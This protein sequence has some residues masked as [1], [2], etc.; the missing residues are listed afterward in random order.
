MAECTDEGVDV[1]SPLSAEAA[2]ESLGFVHLKNDARDS[3]RAE[4]D[5][6]QAISNSDFLYIVNP[7]GYIGPSATFEIGHAV[8]RSVPVFCM[9]APSEPML[10][11]FVLVEPSIKKLKQVLLGGNTLRL[12]PKPDL[13]ALQ[14]YTRDLVRLRGFRDES[15]R[16]V[17]LL[18]VE[19]V[20][21]LARAVRHEIGLKVGIGSDRRGK[22]VA[23]ELADCLVYLLDIAN[24]GGVNLE[25][26]LREKEELNSR[27]T[28]GTPQ[29]NDPRSGV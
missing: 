8:G 15:L 21:E 19:E 6:L 23:Y 29:H 4:A 5:H 7:G 28:W 26:A 9:A 17:V 24:L 18:F 25:A 2:R 27:K 20:G 10:S 22:T 12:P 11:F 16:D 3:K 14:A 13:L 1:L